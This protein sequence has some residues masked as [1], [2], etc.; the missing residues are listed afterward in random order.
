MKR[1]CLQV[2]CFAAAVVVALLLPRPAGAVTISPSAL[3]FGAV[4][5][6]DTGGPLR[7]TVSTYF[8][9]SISGVS[10]S[11]DFAQNNDC[12]ARLPMFGSC[13]IFVTFK[14]LSAGPHTGQL[15]IG[16]GAGAPTLVPLSGTGVSGLGGRVMGAANPVSGSSVTL[17]EAGNSG[18]GTGAT[19]LGTDTSAGDGSFGI[20]LTCPSANAQIYLTAQGGDAGEG[21]NS[22][23]MLMA[24][25]G[26][27][28]SIN[29]HALVIINEVTTAGS[30]YALAQFLSKTI[31][32]TVGTPATN[33]AG[34]ANAFATV[35]NLVDVSNGTARGTTPGGSGRAP[36]RN[37]NTIAN[38][39]GACVQS[40]GAASAQCKELFDCA[41]PGATFNAGGCSGGSGS[42][43]DTLAATLSIAL[44]AA[45]V[46]VAGVFD[47]ATQANL[48]SPALAAAPHDWSMPLNFR[49]AGSNFGFPDGVAIDSSGHVW[50][51]N[52]GTNGVTALNND[53]TLKGN[54]APAGSN[55][56]YP[57]NVAIDSSDHVW[58]PNF[59]GNSVTA[60][61]N[62][63]T[64]LG[65]FAPPGSNFSEPFGVAI[66][67]AGHVWMTN[68]FGRFG[69]SVTALNNDGTLFGYFAP[70]LFDFY[71]PL[72][73]AI[74]SSGH[75]W[76]ANFSGIFRDSVTALNNDGTVFGNFFPSG[77]RFNGPYGVA[78][79]SANHV[80]VTN[81]KGDSVTAL[82]GNGTLFGN[83]APAGSNFSAPYNLAIDGSDHVWVT[84]TYVSSVT[85]L[86]KD[87]TLLGNFAPAGSD[88]NRP[89]GVAI[90]SSGQVWIANYGGNSVTE[91]VGAAAPKKT[92][93]IGPPQLP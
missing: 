87:G 57:Y 21:G 8:W 77:S 89:R 66:D 30:V 88:F 69:H 15:T 25:L 17:W 85:A 33:A 47:V 45:R 20:A 61:N 4:V 16:T 43:A 90:D 12:P 14:P 80:W 1:T 74:D 83:F 34:L 50:V 54:F 62:D 9:A 3:S 42:V 68:F 40:N 7:V 56:N 32:G 49:P 36:E 11:G 13:R 58:T 84:N 5:V 26:R 53:G 22:S 6:G 86:N 59:L 48:F 46:S 60:L 65:N 18:Y 35:P 73:V 75:V 67:A 39:L 82:N 79:D 70:G 55:F 51:A 2:C 81:S 28:G 29:V 19:E 24:A 78:I 52:N 72:G 44:N 93:F 76:V 38:A 31:S 63:G 41:L 91:L 64:L 10:V 23:L 71:E 92:P 37:L 27:C